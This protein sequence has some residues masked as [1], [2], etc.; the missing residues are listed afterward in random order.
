MALND[1]IITISDVRTYRDLSANYSDSRFNAIL[2]EVQNQQLRNLLGDE[3]WLDF[4]LNITD[5]K[6]V[7]LKT[8]ESYSYNSETVYFFGL[9]P[10]LIWSV[11]AIIALEGNVFFGDAGNKTFDELTAPKPAKWE[12]NEIVEGFKTNA[13]DQANNIIQYLNQKAS[14]Y[15]KWNSKNQS[16][17]TNKTLDVL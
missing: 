14:T 4:F 3:L 6:Y 11:L 10:Y 2:L 9:K 7:T 17:I 15:T 16:N 5:S 8:G 1:K 12:I 13:A